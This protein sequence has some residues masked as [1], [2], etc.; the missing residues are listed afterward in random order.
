LNELLTTNPPAL[1]P[2]PF[3]NAVISVL[4][5]TIF[6]IVVACLHLLATRG[7][8]RVELW[9]TLILIAPLIAMATVAVGTNLAAAFT[10]F[11]TLAI[12]RFRT[13]IR[14]PLDAVF[15]IFSVVIGLATGNHNYMVAFVGTVIVGVTI[16]ILTSNSLKKDRSNGKLRVTF[17]PGDTK[18]DSWKT[19]LD[20]LQIEY[21]VLATEIDRVAGTRTI[22]LSTMNLELENS[23]ALISRLQ[24][25]PEITRASHKIDQD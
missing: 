23:Q 3:G 13:R 5:A 1:G 24:E 11:G 2:D 19:V 8:D 10:L 6:G 21:R 12:V 15:V 25:I 18:D 22:M 4:L 17:S 20:E 16:L 14:N 9:R 7:R